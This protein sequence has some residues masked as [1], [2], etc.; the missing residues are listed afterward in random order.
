[1][2]MLFEKETGLVREFH[3]VDAS[4]LLANRPGLYAEA[5]QKQIDEVK[6]KVSESRKRVVARDLVPDEPAL[7]GKGKGRGKK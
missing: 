2:I 1:M 6:A 4:R 3:E 7:P 5:T